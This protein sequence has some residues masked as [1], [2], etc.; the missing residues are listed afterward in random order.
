MTDIPILELP[1]EA[2]IERI[3]AFLSR[4]AKG[5][6]GIMEA[7]I[8]DQHFPLVTGTERIVAKMEQLA[9][10]VAKR[11]SMKVVLV[12]FTARRDV[13]VLSP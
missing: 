1:N 11:S 7:V 10:T 6:E 5:K 9:R 4:D 2:P 13:R 8:G 3:W 12:E